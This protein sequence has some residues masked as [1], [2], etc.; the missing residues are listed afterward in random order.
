MNNI[1]NQLNEALEEEKPNRINQTVVTTQ[2][3][4]NLLLFEIHKEN[5]IH[6]HKS[7]LFPTEELIPQNISTSS[8]RK[9]E[10]YFSSLEKF[11]KKKLEVY[12]KKKDQ[13]VKNA[14]SKNG[15]EEYLKFYQ[16]NHNEAL[17]QFIKR[18][19]EENRIL[20]AEGHLVQQID[21][22]FNDQILPLNLLD[23]RSHFFSP[24]KHF[25]GFRFDT[26]WF[27]ISVIW[28]MV[29]TLFLSLYF[30]VLKKLMTVRFKK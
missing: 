18:S 7:L 22:V 2:R 21:P 20:H 23:Y 10:T 3:H 19:G 24:L 28:L 12:Q 5:L 11:Y 16:K 25:A 27:N 17:D 9:L 29:F 1:T 6:T 30:D 4:Y 15:K 26:F 14:I 13:L 8:V